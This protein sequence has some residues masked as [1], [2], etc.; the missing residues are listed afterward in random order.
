MVS[1]FTLEKP[2]CCA[3]ILAY[4]LVMPRPNDRISM[5]HIATLLAQCLQ[6]PAVQS[7]NFDAIYHSIVGRN[8]LRVFGHHVATC[9]GMMR[10][11]NPTSAHA[12]EQQCSSKLAKRLQHH[13]SFKFEPT[14][15]NTSQQ[16]VPTRATCCTQQCCDMLR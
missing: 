8:M 2:I 12:M 10:D 15:P 4:C 6:A 13:T 1:G 16:G 5:Q 9:F 3:A 14:A 11:E 7:Q